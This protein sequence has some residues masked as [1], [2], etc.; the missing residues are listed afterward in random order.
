MEEQKSGLYIYSGGEN[1]SSK[2][3]PGY[4]EL[5]VTNGI[6]KWIEIVIDSPPVI[7]VSILK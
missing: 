4:W 2:T 5:Q 3:N 1:W 6:P 7:M